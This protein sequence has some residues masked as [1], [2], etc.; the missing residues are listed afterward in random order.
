[1][2]E[3]HDFHSMG[4]S[5]GAPYQ[6]QTQ[7]KIERYQRTLKNVVL[8][9]KYF[10]PWELEKVWLG[11]GVNASDMNWVSSLIFAYIRK[12]KKL[13]SFFLNQIFYV[14]EL[15]QKFVITFAIFKLRE[16][17]RQVVCFFFIVAYREMFNC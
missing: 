9:R 13:F 17:G 5:R 11:N 14:D 6:P 4:H 7:G 1:M 16:R 8:L 15:L 12:R 2:I 10:F 3:Y